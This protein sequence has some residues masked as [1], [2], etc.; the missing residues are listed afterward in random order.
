MFELFVGRP[1][2]EILKLLKVIDWNKFDRVFLPCAGSLSFTFPIVESGYPAEKIFASDISLFSSAL[3][4]FINDEPVEVSFDLDRVSK[5]LEVEKSEALLFYLY[6]KRL[7]GSRNVWE[8]EL[9]K[10]ISASPKKYLDQFLKKI[11]RYKILKG[12]NYKTKDVRDVLKELTDKDVM[13]VNPPFVNKGYSKFFKSVE[14]LW[15]PPF[16]D[17]FKVEEFEKL[18]VETPAIITTSRKVNYK[19]H[20]YKVNMVIRV[21]K[22]KIKV[23]SNFLDTFALKSKKSK[24][25]KKYPFV[26]RED[27]KNAKEIGF[28]KMNKDEA[29]AYRDLFIH[30]LGTV[31]A[32]KYFGI[33][34]NKKLFAVVGLGIRDFF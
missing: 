28:I 14:N 34:I 25:I 33:V 27:L 7:E 22:K 32:E 8:R 1:N 17:E 20:G 29:L 6:L 10:E 31:K 30:R 13:V 11:S 5:D 16:I 23:Y 15:N 24:K 9:F 21:K 18:F 4:Y 26:T 2:R 12:I 19:E 3:N